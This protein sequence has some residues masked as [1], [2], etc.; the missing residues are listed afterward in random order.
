MRSPATQP[1][2]DPV[3]AATAT[4]PTPRAKR[5]PV[6]FLVLLTLFGGIPLAAGAARLVQLAGHPAVTEENARFVHSPAPVVVHVVAAFVYWLAGATQFVPWSWRGHRTWHRWAGRVLLLPAG[7]AVAG[8][9]LWMTLRYPWPEQDGWL[10]AAM[11]LVVGLAMVGALVL[12]VV[13]VRR[14]RFAAHRAWMVRAYALAL[15]AGTQVLTA[16]P[17][18]AVTGS[19]AVGTP[20]ALLL[21]AGWLINAVV[22]EWW[23]RRRPGLGSPATAGARLRRGAPRPA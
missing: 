7:L 17:W 1:A 2:P 4:A 13:E 21:G 16:L 8:S 19:T 12:G 14:R 22:A 18:L 9:G 15:G 6:R 10:L 23:L 5:R 11:R 3:T 20:R